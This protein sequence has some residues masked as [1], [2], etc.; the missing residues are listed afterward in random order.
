MDIQKINWSNRNEVLKAVKENG[1]YIVY[2][3]SEFKKDKEIL[4]EAIGS[5]SEALREVDKSFCVIFP[6][7]ICLEGQS[8]VP[9]TVAI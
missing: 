6:Y 5:N 2:A 9:I 1:L 3:A 8:G 4:L 7:F